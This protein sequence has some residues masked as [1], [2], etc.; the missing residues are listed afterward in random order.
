METRKV[1]LSGGTTYTVSLP[2]R[3]AEESGISAGSVLFLHPE[4]GSLLVETDRQ[5]GAEERSFRHDITEE[6]EATVLQ[7]IEAAYLVGYD[8]VT[9]VHRRGLS[10]ETRMAIDGLVTRL[11]GFEVMEG[12]ERRIVIR[13]LISV[14]SISIRKS[15]LRL[16]LITQAMHRDAV[17]AIVEHDADLAAQVVERDREADKLYGLVVRHFR[18][19]LVDLHE[20]SM[21]GHSR[22]ELFEYYDS[23]RQLER[24]ADHA[25]KIARLVDRLDG[26]LEDP[27]ADPFVECATDARRLV[28]RAC[29]AVFTNSDA[30]AADR[31]L[32]DCEEQM[33]VIEELTRELFAHDDHVN[34]FVASLLLDSIDRT[35][36]Y[37]QNIAEIGHQQGVR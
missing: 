16:S 10:T 32:A 13:S 5:Q 33:A 29:D 34:A 7:L 20:A 19:A 2:K 14:D 4:D 31:V 35:A 28:V 1:Q 3:W 9:L 11:S 22:M 23:A 25:V 26:P 27:F 18:R 15:A 17:T 12:D 21:L 36:G 37:A 8:T 6:D 24:I 30:V